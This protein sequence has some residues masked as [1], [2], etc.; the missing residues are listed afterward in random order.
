M[1]EGNNILFLNGKLLETPMYHHSMVNERFYTAM[2]S[3]SRLS[4]QDDIL[5]VTIPEIIVKSQRLEAGMHICFDGQIRTY[6][7][8]TTD[9][10]SHLVLT[11]FVLNIRDPETNENPNQVELHGTVCKPPKYRVTPF[12]R[13]ITDMIVAVN[14]PHGKSAYVP[15]ITW[16]FTARKSAHLR[17]GDKVS[18]A[19]RLQS[20]NYDKPMIDGTLQ[21]RTA[22]EVSVMRLSKAL[23][24]YLYEEV[25][26]CV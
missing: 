18:I 23:P 5:P 22:Y 11:C 25:S 14:M 21:T 13:E 17:V 4:G 20:R 16:G 12:G 8:C 1:N 26:G 24:D 2:M 6:N 7:K 3:V 15:C 10:T 9:G 19:G